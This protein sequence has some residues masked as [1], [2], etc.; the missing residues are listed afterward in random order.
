MAGH[1]SITI[2]CCFAAVLYLCVTAY[3]AALAQPFT[4]IYNAPP[5]AVPL[6]IESGT[7]VNLGAGGLISGLNAGDKFGTSSNIEVNI[8]GGELIGYY[9]TYAGSTTNISAGRLQADLTTYVGSSVRVLGDDF[10]IDGAPI[11][12]LNTLGDTAAVNLPEGSLLTGTLTDGTPIALFSHYAIDALLDGT[13]TL[14]LAAV[15][16]PGPAII[17]A[18]S[19]PVPTSLRSGQTLNLAAGAEMSDHFI[20]HGATVNVTGGVM[21]LRGEM[22]GTEL[23]VH[24]GSVGSS[25]DV[26]YGSTVNLHP[27][28]SIASF[29]NLFDGS[30]LNMT[31]GSVGILMTAYAG[32]VVNISAGDVNYSFAARD[33]SLVN[34]SGGAIGR[35]FYADVGSTVNITGGRFGR[36]LDVQENSDV[37][38]SGGVFGES[39]SFRSGSRVVISGGE[40]Q[41]DGVP[42]TGLNNIG[43]TLPFNL[44]EGSVLSGT[45]ADGSPFIFTSEARDRIDDG[46]LTL[47]LASLPQPSQLF[48]VPGDAAP[49]GLRDGQTLNLYD[50]GTIPE[51]FAAVHA[52]MNIYGGSVGEVLEVFDSVVN[53][54]GGQI[55]QGM[56]LLPGSTLNLSGGQMGRRLQASA[57]TQVNIVGH[58]FAVNGVYLDHGL[59]VGE[60]LVLEDRDVSLTGILG[61][62]TPFIFSLSHYNFYQLEYFDPDMTLTLTLAAIEG[63]LNGDGFVGI[64]DLNTILTAWNASVTPGD[65]LAGD[66]DGDGFVGIAD[67]N[68]VLANWNVGAPPAS[69]ALSQVPEPSA[70]AVLMAC[71]VLNTLRRKQ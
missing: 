32:S 48:N 56:R 13:L 14:Q 70:V 28:G 51:S 66:T 43:D 9:K 16:A 64:D 25:L 35:S 54:E 63:D 62:G 23:N 42:V 45:M 44:P 71:G 58:S 67:L 7:Q 8:A 59:S 19:D 33:G 10:L 29:L 46:T 49:A 26:L 11:P 21:G 57:D 38:M 41:L 61:D 55:G 65:L 60:S 30:E 37:Y 4:T 6:Y 17:N 20:T 68:T 69:E 12:G 31:G 2:K 27:G 34:I 53:V 5:D 15:P 36:F 3:P 40:F 50:G 18:P 24:S 39:V 1:H 47:A 22:N 52:N